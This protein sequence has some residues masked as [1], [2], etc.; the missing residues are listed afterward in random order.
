MSVRTKLLAAL[1]ALAGATSASASVTYSTGADANHDGKDDQFTVNGAAAYLV[2]STAAGWPVLPN[3]S[4]TSGKYISWDPIQSGRSANTLKNNTYAYAFQFNW[5]GAALTT[6]VDF[7]WVSD[8]YLTDVTLNGVSL[9]VNNIGANEVWKISNV[10][11]VT[12]N[13]AQ[14]LNTL[15]FLVANGGGGATGL[16]ADFTIQGNASLVPEPGSFA[17]FGLGLALIPALRKCSIKG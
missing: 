16:A 11:S 8:D 3:S 2:T 15:Q 6:D 1:I 5:S 9:G 4:I 12:A 10:A 17:L 14:G 13:V 7:R